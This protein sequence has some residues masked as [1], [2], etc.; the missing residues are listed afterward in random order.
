MRA[1]SRVPLNSVRLI[2]H[3]SDDAAVTNRMRV[4][5]V[6]STELRRNLQNHP[7]HR[8]DHFSDESGS[9]DAAMRSVETVKN[10]A[11]TIEEFVKDVPDDVDIAGEVG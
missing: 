3:A 1:E 10:T 11:D 9:P 8:R 6:D 2:F 4:T 5:L 7:D